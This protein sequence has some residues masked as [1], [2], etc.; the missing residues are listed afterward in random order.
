M[1]GSVC[2]IMKKL[3][4]ILLLTMTLAMV[5]LED[6]AAKNYQHFNEPPFTFYTV[7]PGDTFWYLGL[8]YGVDYREL[9]RLNPTVDPLQM[10]I[11]A[12]I[13]LR[14]D[15]ANRQVSR[16]AAIIA[17]GERYIGA[18][19]LFG[20]SPDRTDRFDCSSFVQ[21]VY[22]EGADITLP[23]TTALQAQEGY[24]VSIHHL[25]PGDL[26]FFAI[27]SSHVSHVAIYINENSLL[28]ASSSL[29]VNY[30]SFNHYWRGH[31][32]SARRV[33]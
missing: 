20:A 16:A 14:P 30:T 13:R 25:Q 29:G 4:C 5:D 19:Y 23:R 3:I 15:P 7:Y 10:Q 2:D 17:A 18:P 24:A 1:Y 22:R 28:Q 6:V 11:G 8:R 33:L 9:M 21:R 26:V 27:G 32:H 12:S 31:F